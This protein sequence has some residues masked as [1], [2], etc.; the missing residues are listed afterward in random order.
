MTAPAAPRHSPRI[1][2]VGEP[3]RVVVLHLDRLDELPLV[4]TGSGAAIWHA[5][6]GSGDV[7]EVIRTVAGEFGLPTET[8][9]PDVRAF[10]EDLA[11]RGLIVPQDGTH[12]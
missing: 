9:E 5:V 11:A 4:L 10:L 8:V 3:E 1:A 12:G 6:D 7:D 2:W